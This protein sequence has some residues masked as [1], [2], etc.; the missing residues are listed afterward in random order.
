MVDLGEAPGLGR[1]A[2]SAESSR[3]L[4]TAGAAIQRGGSVSV[5]RPQ[6]RLAP[7]QVMA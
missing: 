2:P 7:I 6:A 5:E 4:E 1:W 3:L